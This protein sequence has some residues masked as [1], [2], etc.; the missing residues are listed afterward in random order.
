M[1]VAWRSSVGIM[2]LD[3]PNAV[4]EPSKIIM[5]ILGLSLLSL[6]TGEMNLLRYICGRESRRMKYKGMGSVI[7]Q[8]NLRSSSVVFA[9]IVAVGM[10]PSV[11]HATPLFKGKDRVSHAIRVNGSSGTKTK[12]LFPIV[13]QIA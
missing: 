3:P 11:S 1:N 2:A 8:G 13:F 10:L 5:M 9:M 4:P 6:R 7:T 12:S